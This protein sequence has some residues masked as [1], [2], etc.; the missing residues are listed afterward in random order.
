M[1][2]TKRKTYLCDICRSM[3][4]KTSKPM[5]FETFFCPK[6]KKNTTLFLKKDKVEETKI[7]EPKEEL[8]QTLTNDVQHELKVISDPMFNIR[9]VIVFVTGFV[10]ALLIT[11]P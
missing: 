5:L 8:E 4:I 7:E 3:G 6:C 11:K 10:I 9:D 2:T 1:I